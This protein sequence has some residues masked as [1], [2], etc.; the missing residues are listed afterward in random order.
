MA[1]RFTHGFVIAFD[2]MKLHWDLDKIDKCFAVIYTNEI[3]LIS[4]DYF[5][6]FNQITR[7]KAEQI[8]SEVFLTRKSC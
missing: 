6:D 1:G 7:Q 5:V 3:N 8:I 4:K 2:A